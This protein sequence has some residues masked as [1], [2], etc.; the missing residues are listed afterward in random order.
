MIISILYAASVVISI[1]LIIAYS[2]I[3]EMEDKEDAV[4]NLIWMIFFAFI[5]MINIVFY[6]VVLNP[7]IVIKYF[8]FNMKDNKLTRFLFKGRL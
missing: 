5:P 1:L 6:L 7:F 2:F 3:Y 4:Y 8:P